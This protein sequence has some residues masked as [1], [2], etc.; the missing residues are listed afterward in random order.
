M[1]IIVANM[2]QKNPWAGLLAPLATAV[3]LVTFANCVLE[4]N[5]APHWAERWAALLEDGTLPPAGRAF[6]KA[7]SLA[8]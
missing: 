2:V 5:F 7:G 1:W 8:A 6:K 4:A 3:P